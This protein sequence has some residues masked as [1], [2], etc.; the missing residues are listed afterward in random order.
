[1]LARAASRGHHSSD[2]TEEAAMARISGRR[3]AAALAL[4]A[5]LAGSAGAATI[6][7]A[8]AGAFP[9][10]S[11]VVVEGAGGVDTAYVSGT[12]GSAS[13]GDTKAQTVDALTKIE[14]TLKS[15]GFGM[16]DVVMMRVFL[17]GDPATGKMDFAGMMA[18]YSQFF[19]TAAKPNK[20]ARTTVQVAGL[21][22]PGS[23]VEIEV[24]AVKTHTRLEPA[25]LK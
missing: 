4:S 11:I 10:S 25:L 12:P 9:I 13:A 21:A 5:L 20:P 7:R 8:G 24:Q 16:G 22:A 23:M 2:V 17:V 3:I 14:T 6:T 18:G 15:K 1:M 19:G